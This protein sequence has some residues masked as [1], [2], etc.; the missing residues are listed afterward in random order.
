MTTA[1]SVCKANEIIVDQSQAVCF[2]N[3]FI[4]PFCNTDISF[5]FMPDTVIRSGNIV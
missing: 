2:V 3:T 5:S 4:D 1:N